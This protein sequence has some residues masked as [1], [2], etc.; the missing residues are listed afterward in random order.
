MFGVVSTLRHDVE[1]EDF[2][3]GVLMYAGGG[4]GT[5]HCSTLQAPVRQCVEL[6]GARGAIIVNRQKYDALM[7]DLRLA[8]RL[9]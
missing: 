9:P 8:H 5:V 6:W 1:V 4:Q 7:A 2:A 3:T